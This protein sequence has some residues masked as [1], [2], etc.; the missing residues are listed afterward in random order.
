MVF[1]EVERCGHKYAVQQRS[2][3]CV[4]A[5]CIFGILAFASSVPAM[6]FAGSQ[7]LLLYVLGSVAGDTYPFCHVSILGRRAG[8]HPYKKTM[9]SPIV[10]V[11]W[12]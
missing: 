9:A 8:A 3:L 2:I 1:N 12:C 10:V 11:G 7:L 6:V 4:F 5:G